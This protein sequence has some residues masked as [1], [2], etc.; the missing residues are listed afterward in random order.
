MNTCPFCTLLKNDTRNQILKRGKNVTAI[1]K[2]YDTTNVNFLII[3][4]KHIINLKDT[5]N[6]HIITEIVD[7]ANDI[8][9]EKDWSMTINNGQ[10]A[11]QTIFHL[12]A[13][14]KSSELMNKWF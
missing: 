9:G 10:L 6:N 12:H 11:N 1:K 5:E 2:L 7:M 8:S 4:N 14:I 13:H 3:P